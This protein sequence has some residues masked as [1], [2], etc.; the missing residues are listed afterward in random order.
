MLEQTNAELSGRLEERDQE[1]D[2]ARAA[3]RELISTV[4]K[5]S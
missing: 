2:A 5:R 3:N 1:L 4:N